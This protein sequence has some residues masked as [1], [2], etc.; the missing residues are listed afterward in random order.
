[1]ENQSLYDFI[2][3]QFSRLLFRVTCIYNSNRL[4]CCFSFLWH[5][6]SSKSWCMPLIPALQLRQEHLKFKAKWSP[7]SK[8]KGKKEISKWE[9]TNNGC[10]LCLPSKVRVEWWRQFDDSSWQLLHKKNSWN[11]SKYKHCT[12]YAVWTFLN[13]C[14]NFSLRVDM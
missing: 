7:I 3:E 8:N 4:C 2:I 12:A 9:E 5:I 14:I 10:R 11:A 13:N 6:R 1:M